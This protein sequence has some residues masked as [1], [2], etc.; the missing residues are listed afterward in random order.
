M[1]DD[2]YTISD[3]TKD[4]GFLLSLTKIFEP[5]AENFWFDPGTDK[6]FSYQ[7][8]ANE[9]GREIV[10][11]QDPMPRGDYYF[12]NPFAE[13]FGKKSP[14]TTLYYR[15]IR[16]AL[17]LNIST[18]MNYVIHSILEAKVAAEA[19]DEYSLSHTVVRMSSVPID[20][21]ST[22]YDVVDE[23]MIDEFVILFKRM[24]DEIIQIPYLT[25]QMTAKIKCDCFTDPQWDE[26]F[27]KDIRKKTLNAFKAVLQGVLGINSPED[28]NSFTVKYDPELKSSA[29]L[30][31]TM[32]VY[33][34]LYNRFNDVIADAFAVEGKPSERD[35]INLGELTATIERFPLAYSIA[36]HMVQV[37]HPKVDPTDT[38]T[39]DTRSLKLGGD[40]GR[41]F[42]S[43]RRFPGPEIIDDFGRKTRQP[44]SLQ[45]GSNSPG[46]GRFKPHIVAD[47]TIDPFAPAIRT[48]STNSN[49]NTGFSSRQATGGYFSPNQNQSG[50]FGGGLNLNPPS[51]FNTPGTR[52]YFS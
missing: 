11:F 2:T 39:S 26:K 43:S 52:R 4:L 30:H 48:P 40:G 47:V 15:A 41:T 34:K 1:V 8:D 5:D 33:L 20:R 50:G 36:K 28:L 24:N 44:Q 37:S 46:S 9:P 7:L 3:V 27:G 51:N 13:G 32:T 17:N 45:I 35:E 25:Q 29:K 10:I 22:V 6:R 16:I 12:F 18:V 21:K 14:A 38:T 23:K 49:N 42:G 19:K 31:T